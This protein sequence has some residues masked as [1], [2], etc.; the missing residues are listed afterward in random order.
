MNKKQRIVLIVATLLFLIS[1]L[2][3]PWQYEYTYLTLT[4]TC[5]ANY[6]FITQ[7]PNN[8]S[9]DLLQERCMTSDPINNVKT[10][11]D[12]TR[13]NT[14]RIILVLF[15]LGLFLGLKE[16]K[17]RLLLFISA[18]LLAAGLVVSQA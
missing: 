7:P 6:G 4:N 5:P 9:Y 2:V 18:I 15:S 10:R 1:E 11:K 8:P 16:R 12:T 17:N 3:P 13:L 14:Q